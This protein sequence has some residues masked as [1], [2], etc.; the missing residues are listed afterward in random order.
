M[1]VTS[2]SPAVAARCL[3]LRP[4]VGAVGSQNVTNPALGTDVLDLLEQGRS[5][6]DSLDQA[7]HGERFAEHR[8]VSVVDRHGR[9]A[10]FSGD[11]SLG[12]HAVAHGEHCV[13]AGN[14]LAHEGVPQAMVDAF[15]NSHAEHLEESLLEAFTGGITA[16]G[17]AGSI[18]SAGLSVVE[19]VPWRV[20]DLRVDDSDDPRGELHRLLELWIPQKEAYRS[21]AIDPTGAPSYGVPGD[22]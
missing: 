7:V 1:V 4:G 8:Q 6:Q 9:V 10:T 3:H 13:A 15:R 17:E 18:R 14:L 21:R 16:G 12:V 19:D 5:A 22:E 20:T 2:S 11:R